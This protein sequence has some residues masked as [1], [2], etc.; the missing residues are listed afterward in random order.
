MR[1]SGA[2]TKGRSLVLWAS[3][4]T[5]LA[6]GCGTEPVTPETITP[7]SV[8]VTPATA[9][10]PTGNNQTFT[11]T[12]QND[13]AANG[14]SWSITGCTGSC[15]SLSGVTST[16][17]IYT[18]PAT[19]PPGTIG[20]TA[21]SVSDGTKSSAAA[22]TIT[23]AQGSGLSIQRTLTSS[24]NQQTDTVGAILP[25]PLRVLVLRGTQPAS[26]ILVTWTASQ[27]T[28]SADS[29]TTDVSGIASVT[30]TL[31]LVAG[32][33]TA[34]AH[35]GGTG[36]ADSAVGF[37]AV[38]QPRSAGRLVFVDQ[39]L[40][41]FAGSTFPPLRVA[42]LDRY[43]NVATDFAG[44]VTVTLSPGGSLVGTTTAKA[45]FGVA[46]FAGLSTSQIGAGYTLAASANGLG[47]ATS[48]PFDVVSQSS[49]RIAFTSDRG[50]CPNIYA[51]NPDGTGTVELTSIG[52]C[53][54]YA[55]GA[56]WSPDGMKIAYDVTPTVW[57]VGR[58][59]WI[60]LMNADGSQPITLVRDTLFGREEAA[61]SP[62]GAK[63]A[64]T[65][66]GLICSIRGGCGP[67]PGNPQ[68]FAVNADGSGFRI[69]VSHGH[70]PSWSPDGTQLAFADHYNP[71]HTVNLID[72]DIYVMNA[73]G[74]GVTNLTNSPGSD[75]SPAWSPDGTRIAFRSNRSGYYDL[76]V[77]NP[78]G[79]GVT[80]LTADT[81]T[82]GRPAWSRDGTKL[83]FASNKDGDNEIYVMNADGTAAIKLTD[84]A[85]WDG[86]PAWTR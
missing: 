23:T 24:G 35:L 72:D 50:G 26:G 14:V 19:A 22:V 38:A 75:D 71:D 21:T 74:T 47:D 25:Q 37:V 64:G 13:T 43:D 11:A 9:S 68:I 60:V 54:E 76:Y 40:N 15:G 66:W 41:V 78:D 45:V 69:L 81:A 58:V 77:M 7:I 20:I 8:A 17:V 55:N 86:R 34:S 29:T 84:N 61:W 79:S 53:G 32:T 57:W 49:G 31:G 44:S 30:W 85:A 10:V 5:S 59:P 12:V 52:Y 3:L 4:C 83:A 56:A 82:E 28:L 65:N 16:G 80:R 39:P 1:D 2:M 42:A 70:T 46:T 48:A 63:I 67:G 6:S 36:V 73:D 62:D 33:Q 51:M 18:A 27:G